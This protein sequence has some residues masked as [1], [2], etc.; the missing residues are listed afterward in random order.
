ME[1]IEDENMTW[2]TLLI[3]L[4]LRKPCKKEIGE[5]VLGP[6]PDLGDRVAPGWLWTRV[7]CERTVQP[8][9]R[10]LW[11]PVGPEQHADRAEMT[12]HKP[13]VTRQRPGPR[14]AVGSCSCPG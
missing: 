7:E 4:L 14:E 9:Q 8:P 2:T 11:G 3:I 1:R 6:Y 12:W 10:G 13:W 5:T